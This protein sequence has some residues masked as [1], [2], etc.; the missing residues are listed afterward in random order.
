[1]QPSCWYRHSPATGLLFANQK[2]K[3][4]AA[5]AVLVVQ[6]IAS[7]LAVAAL[8]LPVSRVK[9]GPR[10]ERTIYLF[11]SDSAFDVVRDSDWDTDMKWYSASIFL[12][13][14]LALA[15]GTSETF[16]IDPTQKQHATFTSPA[17][18]TLL[19]IYV[20]TALIV[21]LVPSLAHSLFV[22]SETDDG[23]ETH[24]AAGGYLAMATVVVAPVART[25]AVIAA[26]AA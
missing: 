26:A 6:I 5:H 19:A 16:A 14:A 25:I 13:V 9:L 17:V 20:T 4:M 15:V 23:A 2:K 7:V 1:M 8:L 12:A 18:K 10:T 24:V 22:K 3:K 11:D 21:I